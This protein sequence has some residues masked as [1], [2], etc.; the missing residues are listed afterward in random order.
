MRITAILVLRTPGDAASDSPS[1]SSTGR[2]QPAVVLAKAWDVSRF[3]FFKRFAARKFIVSIARTVA[4][5]TAAGRRQTVQHKGTP[6]LLSAL[7]RLILLLCRS[8]VLN[9][10]WSDAE[11]KVHCYNPNGLCA[12]M[13]TDDHYP[14]RSAH[15]ILVKVPHACRVLY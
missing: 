9:P 10:I 12:V 5:S 11:Y 6:I 14:N 15:S 7:G 2:E 13:F 3:G 4:L 8:R 1:P